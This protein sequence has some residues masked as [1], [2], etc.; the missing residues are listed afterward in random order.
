MPWNG[1]WAAAA[2]ATALVFPISAYAVPS[3]GGVNAQWSASG[4]LHLAFSFAVGPP[5][6]VGMAIA[7]SAGIIQRR[8]PG[9]FRTAFNACN[10]VLSDTTAWLIFRA[11]VGPHPATPTFALAGAAAAVAHAILNQ[12]LLVGAQQLAHEE[13]DL[14]DWLRHARTAVPID[15][16]FGITASAASVLYRIQGTWGVLALILPV[17]IF[18]AS[19]VALARHAHET[20]LAHVRESDALKR[21]AEA[22]TREREQIAADI[23]DGVV[24]DL[25]GLSFRLDGYSGVDPATLTP[26]Q[27]AAVVRLIAQASA[28]TREAA[29]DLRTLLIEIAP[30]RLRAQG[31]NAALGDLAEA[32]VPDPMPEIRLDVCEEACPD[33][34]TRALAY[35]VAQEALRNSVKYAAAT[36]IQISVAREGAD[37]VVRIRDDG[38]GFSLDALARRQEQGHVGLSLLERT[39]IDGGGA[40]RVDS[41]L[42]QGTLVELRVPPGPAP[43]LAHD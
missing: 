4:F 42:G 18:Q 31:L 30:P 38:R 7:Q 11:I 32:L 23:H 29:R 24:Q 39:A 20:S 22:S 27:A 9:A 15:V 10:S 14:L 37:L 25:A 3:F 2:I 28:T 5:A 34:A 1:N 41:N 21:A 33:E 6:I 35:R 13:P 26:E 43:R 40:L 17:V 12:A 19:L 8:R 36:V 16:A